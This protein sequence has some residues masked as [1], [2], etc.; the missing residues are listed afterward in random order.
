MVNYGSNKT[1]LKYKFLRVE[2]KA[3]YEY[4]S[5]YHCEDTS[6]MGFS[7]LAVLEAGTLLSNICFEKQFLAHHLL[8]SA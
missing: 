3:N 6:E 5:G 4:N 1:T 7:I 8:P 2:N